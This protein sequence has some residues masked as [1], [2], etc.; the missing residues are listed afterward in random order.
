MSSS[1]NMFFLFAL[2]SVL[3][4]ILFFVDLCTGSVFI[5]V[6]EVISV[7]SGHKS[8]VPEWHFIVT[9]YRLP[10]AW[11]ALFAGMALSV[12]GLQ[13]QTLF[14]NPLAGPYVL[15]IMSGANLGVALLVMGVSWFI[16]GE[17]A[18]IV[19]SFSV[20][21]AAWTGAFVVLLLVMMVS[22]R[23]N[24]MMTL[25]VLGM[26]F[27]GASSAV[28]NMLQYFTH[29][30]A[31][32]TFVVWTMG[33]LS[34]I[35]PDDLYI[36]IPPIVA[37]LF[38]SFMMSQKM[39]VL[40]LGDTYARSMGLN[41]RFIRW[42]IFISTCLLAGT[43]TAFCGPI[44]FIGVVVPHL[45]RMFFRTTNHWILH[46]ACMLLGG[47]LLLSGDI[48]SRLPGHAVQL[49]VDAVTALIGIPVMIWIIVKNFRFVSV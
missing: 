33:S 25:L 10:K 35:S 43:V 3:L 44:G 47:M 14:R 23:V 36:F 12:S 28:V 1:K 26:L 8:S 24:D 4:L 30:S 17:Y 38:L 22:L 42:M 9:D 39:N 32:K 46:G 2:F 34:G 16:H 29:E 40:L 15:G 6:K 45:A 37:G 21:A 48:L 31:L 7:L 18:G 41:I 27:T 19:G 11:V 20:V 13:M 49:P 5:P